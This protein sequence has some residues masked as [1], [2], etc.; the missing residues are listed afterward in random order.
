LDELGTV[1]GSGD[2]DPL[3]EALNALPPNARL[4]PAVD[5][6]EELFT[7]CRSE[8]ERAA[9]IE[10]LARAAADPDGRAVVAVALRADFYGR[11]AAYPQIAELLGANHVLVPPMQASELRRAV[12]LPAARVGLGVE[13]ELADALVD[14]VEGEPGALPWSP[15]R[16]SSSG[17]SGR[18]TH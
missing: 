17:R 4:L 14:D 13:L 7:S 2:A 11:F 12:E 16:C 6:L 18:T 3:G 10:T 5:Q 9:F 1:L 15:L 8:A